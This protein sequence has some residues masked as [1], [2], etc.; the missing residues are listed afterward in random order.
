MEPIES[1]QVCTVCCVAILDGSKVKF[2][3]GPMGTRERLAARVCHNLK[4]EHADKRLRCINQGIPESAITDA[5]RYG[6][7][8]LL[9]K[10]KDIQSRY[11]PTPSL[12]P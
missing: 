9:A 8:A 1:I 6:D 3:Y 5:D 2:S 10:L 4:G 7:P 12:T 11:I